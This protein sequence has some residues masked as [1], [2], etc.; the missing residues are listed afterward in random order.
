MVISVSPS[1]VPHRS[2]SVHLGRVDKLADDDSD[3]E[4]LK[5]D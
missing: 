4:I 2:S 5:L 3:L 1:V